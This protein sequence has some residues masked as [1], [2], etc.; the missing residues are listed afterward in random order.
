MF[1]FL[2]GLFIGAR[3]I[4]KLVDHASSLPASRAV[5]T[6]P[7][8]FGVKVNSSVPPNGFDGVSASIS[9]MTSIGSPSGTF[10]ANR[11]L[12]RPSFHVSQCLM[13][14][15]SYTLP[16]D[17][18][19]AILSSFSFVCLG[20]VFGNTS[21]VNAIFEPVGDVMRLLT[22]R[23]RLVICADSPPVVVIFQT[24]DDL[25][26]VERKYI[27]FESAAQ[28]GLKSDAGL[29]VSCLVP[30]PSGFMSHRSVVPLL[31]LRSVFRRVKTIELPSGDSWGSEMR[32]IA[33]MSSMENGWVSA[34]VRRDER[35]V[36]MTINSVLRMNSSF[37]KGYYCIGYC[38]VVA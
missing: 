13:N 3:Y 15:E 23:G 28:R 11:W 34:A 5:K 31:A 8:P 26:R 29:V 33:S 19:S 32:S 12:R 6:N 37:E 2:S 20:V 24:C 30:V 27:D 25:E 21:I 9:F 7:R 16:V 10:I 14:R 4:S 17:F 38:S 22:S 36:K 1:S 35:A 18:C